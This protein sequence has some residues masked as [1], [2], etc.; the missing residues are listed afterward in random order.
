MSSTT[1]MRCAAPWPPCWVRYAWGCETFATAEDFLAVATPDMR[2]CLLLDVRMPGMSGLELQQELGKAGSILPIIFMTGHGDVPMAVQAMKEGAFDFLQKPFRDQDLLDRIQKYLKDD[3]DYWQ[4]RQ[5]RDKAAARF[6]RLTPR[7]LAVME[8]IAA[9][10]HTKGIAAQLDI[11][12]RT[13]DV[14][15]FNIMRKVGARTLAELLQYWSAA[16][17]APEA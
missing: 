12:G 1:T 8:L 11:Q 17:Q 5:A 14:H 15:R 6:A 16:R 7:E 13:V 4:A 10:S 3:L 9:G 2:G